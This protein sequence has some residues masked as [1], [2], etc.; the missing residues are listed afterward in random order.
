MAL[1]G[2]ELAANAT[3]FVQSLSLKVYLVTF[4]HPFN[5]R[6]FFIQ[7]AV[8]SFQ[9]ARRVVEKVKTYFRFSALFATLEIRFL[10]CLNFLLY[11]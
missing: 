2:P 7:R 3:A 9:R 11:E 6:F 1:F 5:K 4:N 8:N 10:F